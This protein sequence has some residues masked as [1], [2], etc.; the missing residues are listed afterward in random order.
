[1]KLLQKTVGTIVDENFIY[2]RAL[3][4]LGISFYENEH[5]KLEQMCLDRNIDKS[6]LIRTLYMVDSSFRLK[7]KDIRKFPLNLTIAYLQYAHQ[8]YIKVQ[9]PYVSKLIGNLPEGSDCIRDLKTV[10]PLFVEDFIIHIYEEEDTLFEYVS[11][12]TKIE[13]GSISNPI[14]KLWKFSGLSLNELLEHHVND[15]AMSNMRELIESIPPTGRHI[16]VIIKELQAFDREI[17]YHA[18]IE[19]ELFF[20][21]AITLEQRVFGQLKKISVYN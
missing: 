21:Q 15:D 20:P 6:K 3:H 12:L 10:F 13:S 14:S 16:E 5:L 17:L 1:M 11:L 8:Q 4:F 7:F 19:N 9:L 18:E 2:A